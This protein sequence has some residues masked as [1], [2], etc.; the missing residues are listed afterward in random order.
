MRSYTTHFFFHLSAHMDSL[1]LVLL[2]LTHC[3]LEAQYLSI[4]EY[5]Y[6]RWKQKH[7]FDTRPPNLFDSFDQED[8]RPK[9]V[10]TAC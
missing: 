1:D 10:T 9:R 5:P 3:A 7:K 8:D 4:L 2:L 6:M